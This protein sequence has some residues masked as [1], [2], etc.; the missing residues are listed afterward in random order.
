LVSLMEKERLKVF[1][2]HIPRSFAQGSF[3][4]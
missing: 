3:N 1:S 2:E 4:Q